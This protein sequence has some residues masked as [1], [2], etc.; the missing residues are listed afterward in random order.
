MPDQ[1][2]MQMPASPGDSSWTDA[3]PT[4]PTSGSVGA[5]IDYEQIPV[6]ELIRLTRELT[7]RITN[8]DRQRLAMELR[9]TG[10]Q[11]TIQTRAPIELQQFFRGEI[12]LDTELARRFS[13]APLLSEINVQKPTIERRVSTILS[14][15]DNAATLTFDLHLETGLLEIAFTLNS[16][17]SLRFQLSGVKMDDR[18]RWLDLMRRSSGI[19][20]LWTTTRWESDYLI[21]VVRENFARVYAFAPQR[22]EA[23]AR[24][25][26]DVLASLLDWLE[27]LWLSETARPPS[28]KQA[29]QPLARLEAEDAAT[30]DASPELPDDEDPSSS[31]SFEW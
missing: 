4:A 27:S 31:A 3:A 21:F 14:T 26:P 18:Q 13:Q 24:M 29:T 16:M 17:L 7:Q 25:T 28:A 30:M 6:E 22:F 8:A 15:Q 9:E 19:A 10:H 12:D 5:P 11:R 20:F 2:N 23:G 1:T